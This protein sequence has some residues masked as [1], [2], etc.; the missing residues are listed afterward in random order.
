MSDHDQWP[1]CANSGRSRSGGY[2]VKLTFGSRL[3]SAQS[4]STNNH[5]AA[6][7]LYVDGGRGARVMGETRKIAAILVADVVGYSRLAGADEDA[8]GWLTRL[9]D[10]VSIN[11]ID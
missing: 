10:R 4:P 6:V 2:W 9:L 11:S 5:A 1:L 3:S 7:G 8:G